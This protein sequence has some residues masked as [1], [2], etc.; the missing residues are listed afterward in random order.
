MPLAN[1]VVK[2]NYHTHMYL[3]KHATGH[4]KDYV[5]EAIKL[6]FHSLGMSDH[7]PFAVLKDRE[8]ADVSRGASALLRRIKRSDR[9]LRPQNQ[10]LERPRN[11]ILPRPNDHVLRSSGRFGL[12]RAWTALHSRRR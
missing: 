9:S 1:Q 5:K 7:A 4:V 3:C 10:N 2:N 11:R 6:G 8:R 12:F